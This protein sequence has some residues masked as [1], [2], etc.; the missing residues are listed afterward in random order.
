VNGVRV[1]KSFGLEATRIGVFEEQ[2]AAFAVDARAA[3][4]FAAQ[5]IPIPQF[6][7]ALSYVWVL[8]YGSRLVGEGSLT[9][10]ALVASLLTV[11]ALVLRFE[12][13]GSVMQTFADA[14]SSAVRIWDLLDEEPAIHS[15]ERTLPKGPLGLKFDAVRVATPDGGND[16]LKDVSFEIEPGEIVAL[17]GNTG[18]GKSTLMGLLPRLFATD[19]GAV[20]VGS[21]EAG[22]HDVRSLQLKDL[23]D[24]VHVLPQESFL[25]SDSL[26]ANLRLTAPA[27]QDGELVHALGRAAAED[28]LSGLPDGLDARIGDKGVTLS[29]GQRQRVCLARGIL[30]GASV[31]GF[32]DSTSALDAATERTVLENIRELRRDSARATT[33]LIVTNRLST[34][35]MADRVLLLGGGRIAAKGSHDELSASSSAYRDLMGI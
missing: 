34:I 23:R 24:R 29:G 13:V 12:G 8:A 30:S 4:R 20:S 6:I 22:W 19:A 25:F 7:V 27:A 26:S 33:L 28:I 31:L 35:L 18:A 14:R 21:D 10:G 17:V 11:N 2:V 32:D 5:K 1:I 15:G 3:L 16:I 9:V